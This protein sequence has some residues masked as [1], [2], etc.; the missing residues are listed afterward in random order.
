MSAPDNI[1]E[2]PVRKNYR[3]RCNVR[4]PLAP[5]LPGYAPHFENI[6]KVGGKT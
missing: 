1:I 2:A 4:E 3:I 5:A 6:G